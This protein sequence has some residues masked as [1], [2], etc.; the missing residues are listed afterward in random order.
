MSEADSD[1]ESD[2]IRRTKRS[3]VVKFNFDSS[4]SGS[5]SDGPTVSA[6]S[7]LPRAHS[8]R[9]N[10]VL[11]M[12]YA[13]VFRFHCCSERIIWTT[14]MIRRVTMSGIPAQRHGP[15]HQQWHCRRLRRRQQ[16]RLQRLPHRRQV[17]ELLRQ[18]PPTIQPL[19]IQTVAMTRL[20]YVYNPLPHRLSRRYRR[21][22]AP[23]NPLFSLVPFQ[24]CPICLH[25]FRDQEIGT[26]NICEHSFCAPCIDEW[27]GNV[28]TC[29]IDRK[30]FDSI[31]VRSRF[32]GGVFVRDVPVAAKS[33]ELKTEF[34]FTN[35]EV[36]NSSE[37]EETMLLCDSCN[38][39]YHME[40]LVPPLTEIPEGSWYCDY[41]FES[42][43]SEED[44]SRLTEELQAEIGIT[45][46]RLRVQRVIPRA[47]RIP[48]TRQSERIRAT[49]LNRRRDNSQNEMAVVDI[50]MPGKSVDG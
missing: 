9:N 45:E 47:P 20:M 29:P 36:C 7:N 19:Q 49:I 14:L 25:T 40:C 34:D 1:S 32:A 43:S 22:T 16:Q 2:K 39:G 10:F 24:K 31:R 44:I 21:L 17:A 8:S 3:V 41:C 11:L 28:Q 38:A 33:T 12:R 4:E 23:P 30:P 6:N 46:T 27:S 5:D 15:P 26:P 35:C 48:R 13:G 42:E 18:P 50:T 37:R